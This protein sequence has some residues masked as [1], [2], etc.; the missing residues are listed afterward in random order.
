MS[1]PVLNIFRIILY[2]EF[3]FNWITYL[4]LKVNS[5]HENLSPLMAAGHQGH[6][7][8]VKLLLQNGARI[9]ASNKDGMT[10]LMVSIAG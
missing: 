10:P 7:N 5:W 9:N 3:L 8:V 2:N 4:N 1:I 6:E